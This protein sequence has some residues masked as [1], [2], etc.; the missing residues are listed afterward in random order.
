M[1]STRRAS[2]LWIPGH[3]PAVSASMKEK[4]RNRALGM[5]ATI[6]RRDFLDS[7]LLAS[8]A[9]LLE[10][11]TPSQLLAQTDDWTGYGGVGEYSRSNGNTLEVLQTGHKMR[12]AAYD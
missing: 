9:A 8:G 5:N 4:P 11:L 7:T 12:D 3:D 1:N 6:T 2:I 10:G